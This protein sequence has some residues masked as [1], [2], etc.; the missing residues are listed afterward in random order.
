MPKDSPFY[1]ER[2]QQA[3]VDAD[4]ANIQL[5]DADEVEEDNDGSMAEELSEAEETEL[6]LIVASCTRS[7][8]AYLDDRLLLNIGMDEH[9]LLALKT[10][11]TV[12]KHVLSHSDL[13]SI[14]AEIALLALFP[15]MA[16]ISNRQ[17]TLWLEHQKSKLATLLTRVIGSHSQH[18]A[19]HVDESTPFAASVLDN[20][21]ILSATVTGYFTHLDVL[22]P[23][24]STAHHIP[25]CTA[26]PPLNQPSTDG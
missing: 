3:D 23:F 14:D 9:V 10:L 25:R 22:A 16:D 11:N 15:D 19:V 5:G 7:V 13:L 26:L 18:A 24:V 21:T 20:F 2:K 1:I 6:R 4:D 17:V 12:C 8:S